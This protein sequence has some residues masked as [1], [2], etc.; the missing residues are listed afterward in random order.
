[1]DEHSIQLA[2]DLFFGH[3][4]NNFHHCHQYNLKI[5]KSKQLTT[6]DWLELAKFQD[7]PMRKS[8]FF[9]PL[10]QAPFPQRNAYVGQGVAAQYFTSSSLPSLHSGLPSHSLSVSMHSPLS[11]W[12]LVRLHE[13]CSCCSVL[14]GH[15]LVASSD[16][17]IGMNDVCVW[18]PIFLSQKTN[19][20]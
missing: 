14:V 18:K 17:S 4:V 2:F 10:M 7:I 16:P 9:L 1:M 20:D 5:K 15:L 3:T 8:H 12:K 19:L 13:P 11:H 6:L